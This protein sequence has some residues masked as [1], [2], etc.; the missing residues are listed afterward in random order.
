VLV[1]HRACEQEQE[2]DEENPSD[3]IDTRSLALVSCNVHRRFSKVVVDVCPRTLRVCVCVCVCA[4]VCACVLCVGEVGSRFIPAH[5]IRLPRRPTPFTSQREPRRP[6]GPYRR[7]NIRLGGARDRGTGA[8]AGARELAVR[9]RRAGAYAV[10][11][12]GVPVAVA[13]PTG[14]GQRGA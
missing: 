9:V 8:V 3:E 13:E 1:L 12:D 11:G 5:L 14:P 6:H 10:D 7:E 4:C 2:R